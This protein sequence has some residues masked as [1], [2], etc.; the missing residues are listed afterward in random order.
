M[1]TTKL[2]AAH[3]TPTCVECDRM[4]PKQTSKAATTLSRWKRSVI[5]D[6]KARIKQSLERAQLRYKVYRGN[7]DQTF[8][9]STFAQ[10]GEDLIVLNIFSLLGIAK[11]SYLD[12]GAHHPIHCSNTALMHLRGSRGI[13]VEANPNLIRAFHWHRPGDTTVNVGVG[14]KR[15][16]LNFHFIDDWSGRNT[17]NRDV[18]DEFVRSNP[19]LRICEV[20]PIPVVTL[21]DIVAQ[22]AGGEFP[23]FLSLDVE[24]L[25][26][27]IL[28]NSLFESSKPVVICVEACFGSES[29]DSTR[30][31]ALLTGCGYALF[32]RTIAN[33]IFVHCSNSAK[34]GIPHPV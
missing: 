11:P 2:G 30:L 10:H 20:R 5:N 1:L 26:F 4:T 31:I 19:S 29:D 3:V 9:G 33:L 14:P 21:N 17:F 12:V 34:L 8:G 32:M 13:N 18:A 28:K 22:Y 27:D 24:G 6:V 25:D 23:D 16:T 7:R 15:G